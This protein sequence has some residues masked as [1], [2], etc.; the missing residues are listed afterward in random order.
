MELQIKVD[1]RIPKEVESAIELLTSLSK[2]VEV[3]PEPVKSDKP[4]VEKSEPSD[5]SITLDDIRAK[6]KELIQG[7]K[8]SEVKELLS[9]FDADTVTKLE[10]A[11]YADFMAAASE[12]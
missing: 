8:R 1:T 6:V 9:K 3:S 4:Q 2:R 7:G 5:N 12:L 11:Q 10:E